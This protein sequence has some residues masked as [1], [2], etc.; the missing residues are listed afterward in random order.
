MIPILL[1]FLKF[2]MFHV[3]KHAFFREEVARAHDLPE[4]NLESL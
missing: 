1:A 3:R 4:K 2:P